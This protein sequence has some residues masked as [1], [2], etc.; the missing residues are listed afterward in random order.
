MA[1]V[2]IKK[3][4]FKYNAVRYYRGKSEDVVLGCY[5]DK[6]TPAGNGNY[7]DIADKLNKAAFESV[8]VHV[9]GPIDVDWNKTSK[10]DLDLSGSLKFIKLGGA[11][12][13]LTHESAKSAKLKLMKFSIYKNPLRDAVNTHDQAALDFIKGA[14]KRRIVSAVW[15]AMEAELASKVATGVEVEI[16]ATVNGVELKVKGGTSSTTTTN[17]K[18]GSNTTFAYMLHKISSLNAQGTIGTMDDDQHGAF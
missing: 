11:K 16:D 6:M 17:V 1:T 14:K 2:K 5:G 4:A 12:G 3:N 13:N 9:V 18:L 8:S 7:L 10:S 15:V